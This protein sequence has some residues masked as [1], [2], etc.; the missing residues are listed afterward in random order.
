MFMS[1]QR[2]RKVATY[3]SKDRETSREFFDLERRG[4]MLDLSRGDLE[5]V[6]RAAVAIS[7]FQDGRRS[8]FPSA[9]DFVCDLLDIDPDGPAQ[10]CEVGYRNSQLLKL[11]YK[12]YERFVEQVL[13]N[14]TTRV[15]IKCDQCG[16]PTLS[17]QIGTFLLPDEDGIFEPDNMPRLVRVDIGCTCQEY[18]I[19]D[20]LSLERRFLDCYQEQE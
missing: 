1:G 17:G 19:E 9:E 6:Q 14:I 8:V 12:F 20:Y 7:A 2:L 3:A 15:V 13:E 16:G 5:I 18:E 11:V 4:K 10:S